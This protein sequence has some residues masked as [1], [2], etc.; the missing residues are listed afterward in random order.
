MKVATFIALV[1]E[2]VLMN[3]CNYDTVFFIVGV[4]QFRKV[5]QCTV[6]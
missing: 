5:Q 2:I 6:V 1:K 4:T 3:L